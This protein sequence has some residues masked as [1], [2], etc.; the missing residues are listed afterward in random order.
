MALNG[1]CESGMHTIFIVV[2]D[3]NG[4]P[5][6][7][8]VVGDTWDNVEDVSG[9]KGPGRAEIDLYSNTM[10]ITVKRDLE[11]GELSTSE[12]SPPCSSFITTISDEQLVQGGYFV[13]EVEA[14]WNREN[15]G[16]KCGGH[17]S[18]EVIFQRMY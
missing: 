16:Y 2:Q 4:T 10:E 15:Y 7:G 6:D 8:V 14:Q 17:F 9:R 3:A 1:G 18:W 11:T 13:N 5:L 12:A